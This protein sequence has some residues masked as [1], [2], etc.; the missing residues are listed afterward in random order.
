MTRSIQASGCIA[1]PVTEGTACAFTGHRPAKLPWRY[2]ESAPGCLALTAALETQIAALAAAGITDFISGMALGTDTICARIVLALRK[3]NPAIRL[4][5]AL[6]CSSQA[7]RWTV[8]ERE[9]YQAILADAD[10]VILVNQ[11]GTPECMLKRNRFMVERAAVLLAVYN[12]EYRGGTAMTVRYARKL[13]RELFILNPVTLE[14]VHEA[15][16]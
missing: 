4:F 14:M 15:N 2:D 9:Q 16:R 8:S 5:C 3:E 6:P 10:S 11:D 7:D 1:G 12:G 13:R